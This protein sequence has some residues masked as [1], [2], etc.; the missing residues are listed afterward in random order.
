MHEAEGHN[1]QIKQMRLLVESFWTINT[2]TGMEYFPEQRVY[3]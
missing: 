1:T 2:V 3:G